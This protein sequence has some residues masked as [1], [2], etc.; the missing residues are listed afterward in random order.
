[1]KSFFLIIGSIIFVSYGSS[2]PIE[3]LQDYINIAKSNSPRAK[4]AQTKKEISQYQF[5]TFISDL[6][7]QI[8]FYGN[9]P[10]Y[11]K[12]FFNVVQPDG[13]IKFLPR[14]Q[15]LP[16][17]GFSLS[18][19]LLSTGGL[20]SLR[21]DISRFDDFILKTKSYNSTPIYLRLDQPLFGFNQLKWNK[22]IEPLKVVEADRS[23]IFEMQKIAFDICKDYFEVLEA[24]T[25]Y[26]IAQS[27]IIN[28]KELSEIEQKRVLLGTTSEDKILQLQLQSIQAKQRANQAKYDVQITLLKLNT[29][30]G[31]KNNQLVQLT[32]PEPSQFL[33]VN[34]DSA[35]H[36][37]KILRPEFI[38]FQRTSMES[39]RDVLRA[40]AD[41]KQVNLSASFGYNNAANNFGELYSNILNQ[42]RLSIGFDVPIVD[43][44]R[45]DAR[46]NTAKAIQ[47]LN[48]YTNELDEQ[49]YIQE[50]TTVVNTLDL[51]RSNIITAKETSTIADNRYM[52]SS[53]QYQSGKLNL[54]ELN[55]AQQENNQAD[56]NYIQALKAYWS[57][58][59]QLRQ[60]TLFDF[61]LGSE[62]KK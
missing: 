39:E 31:I 34:L 18:Q 56:L 17:I 32:I 51:L 3:T 5:Q 10:A 42:Q 44:G 45:R 54:T 43:W 15:N 14:K 12:D 55:I 21:S 48:Q 38:A 33:S 29:D 57:S 53:Q 61:D 2:Q 60:L 58:Y 26:E 19:H 1:M 27:N 6:R 47:K 24:Q 13:T 36:Y 40:Q 25:K 35:I 9:V 7:P 50:I 20:I 23:E 30:A 46:Y 8:S 59:Y 28:L 16:N 4:L 62:I 41:K 37:A 22:K 11:S 52:L 49:T